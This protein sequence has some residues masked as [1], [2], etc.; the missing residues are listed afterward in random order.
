M[1]D[2][3]L[4]GLAAL[5]GWALLTWAVAALVSAWAWPIS[6]GLLLLS[7]TGWR[8][9]AVVVWEGLYALTRDDDEN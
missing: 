9:I 7:L 8:L 1:R 2:E 6:G 3:A 4:T 5:A